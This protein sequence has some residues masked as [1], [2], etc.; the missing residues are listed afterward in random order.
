MMGGMRQAGWVVY[1][2]HIDNSS[3]YCDKVGQNEKLYMYI[4]VRVYIY[5]KMVFKIF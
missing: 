2:C 1:I 5:E 4:C 3:R